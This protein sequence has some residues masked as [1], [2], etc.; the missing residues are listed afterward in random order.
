MNPRL[1]SVDAWGAYST[2]AAFLAVSSE[3]PPEGPNA[4]AVSC[5]SDF[6]G[7]ICFTATDVLLDNTVPHLMSASV[8]LRGDPAHFVTVAA[9]AGAADGGY[10]GEGW[11]GT[12]LTLSSEWR[13]VTITYTVAANELSVPWRPWV[14]LVARN[15]GLHTF[16]VAAPMIV[17]GVPQPYAAGGMPGVAWAG[18]PDASRSVGVV[19]SL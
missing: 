1:P 19:R 14:Q 17:Q 9:R 8:W 12:N 4:L 7:V 13:R 15:G 10:L 5:D 18:T 3:S 6:D 16:D 11:G 2:P